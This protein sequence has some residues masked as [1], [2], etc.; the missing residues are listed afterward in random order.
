MTARVRFRSPLGILAIEA[1][2]AG[3]LGL[4]FGDRGPGRPGVSARARAHLDGAVE[5]LDD[6]F[7]GIR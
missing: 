2:D 6:Y 3:V 1:S 7:A 5:A 4:P